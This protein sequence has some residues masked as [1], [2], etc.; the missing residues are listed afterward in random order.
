MDQ[1]PR[2]RAVPG[3]LA[4]QVSRP[5][6]HDPNSSPPSPTASHDS[7]GDDP[8]DGFARGAVPS[9]TPSSVS[10]EQSLRWSTGRPCAIADQTSAA[11]STAGSDDALPVADRAPRLAEIEAEIGIYEHR[12]E[13]VI[14]RAAAQGIVIE[15]R[16]DQSPA[17]I[18]GVLANPATA[19]VAA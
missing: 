16:H 18:L 6:S 10:G 17:S 14:E 5:G 7:P 19:R 8:G 9:A 11:S 4:W 1:C 12:E 13:A 15:R 2:A 3:G